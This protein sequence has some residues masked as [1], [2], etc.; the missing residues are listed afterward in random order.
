MQLFGIRARGV[1]IICEP[2]PE[3]SSTAV[4]FQKHP[5]T[6]LDSVAIVLL[7]CRLAAARLASAGPLASSNGY[8][9]LN[10]PLF[11]LLSRMRRRRNV[12][13]V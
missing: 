8:L 7:A 4:R 9:L 6:A 3:N 12:R 2:P 13:R 10:A 5:N 1:V 11:I